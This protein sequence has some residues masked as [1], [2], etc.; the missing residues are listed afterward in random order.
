MSVFPHLHV[1]SAHSN[2][3]G[4]A[5][6]EELV[7]RVAEWGATEAAITDRDGLY[8]A[9][10]HIR[11]CISAGIAPV[12]GVDLAL[13]SAEGITTDARVTVL[14]HGSDALGSNAGLGW[15]ALCRL[16][17]AAHV[18]PRKASAT[19]KREH[20]AS[21]EPR[22]FAPFLL[23]ETEQQGAGR[24]GSEQLGTVLLGPHSDV[25]RALAAGHK[26]RARERLGQ[27]QRRLRG[28][29]A[30]EIVCHLTEPGTSASLSHAA[31]MLELAH[32]VRV[33][34]VLTNQARYLEPDDAVTGDVLDAAEALKPLGEFQPQPN[35]QAWLKPPERMRALA[36]LIV[37]RTSLGSA[38]RERLLGQTA[39]LAARCRLDPELDVRWR[40]PKVPEQ[41][42]LGITGD[43]D[44]VLRNRCLAALNERF[45]SPVGAQRETLERRLY[46]ELDTI[47]GFGFATYFLAVANVSELIRDMGIRNQARGSGAS[48][49]VNYL[50]RV[51]NVNPIEHDLVFERFL[52]NKRSTLPDID[53]DV[54]SDRRHEIYRAIF[55]RYGSER[56]TLLSM[57][58]TYRARGAARDAGLALGLE[59]HR[60]DEIA[61]SLWR[62]NAGQFREVLAEKPELAELA[63][64]AQ[65]DRDLN[66][67]IDLAERLD[68]LPRHLS[69]HP[70]GVLL[71]DATMLSTT[72]V[73]PSGIGLP[74][75]QYDKDDIDDMGL[76]KLDV[77]G[78]RMQSSLAYAVKEVE[79]VHGAQAAVRGGLSPD[80][81]YVSPTGHI[82]LDEIPKD[83]ERTFEAIRST[84]TLGMFQ[85]ESPGQR[86]L[87]GKMQPDV[88]EDLIADISLFRP[89]PMKGNMVGPFLDV[90]HGFASPKWLHPD[91]R[92]FLHET[93]GVVVYHEQVLRIFHA[94]MGISLAEADEL[95]RR[96]ERSAEGIE[97]Q[98][99]AKTSRNLDASGKRKFTDRQI[100]EIWDVLKGFGS[101]GFCK[102]HAAAFALPT[103]Q[104]AWLKTHYPAEFF[105]GLLTHD[106]G[107]YPKRLLLGD[108]R[109][110]GVPILPVDVQVS[111]EH[112]V[113]ERVRNTPPGWATRTGD[114]GIRLALAEIRGMNEAERK[115]IIAE[116]PYESL[117]DFLTRAR[118]SRPLAERLALI[119]ALDTLEPGH[120]TRGELLAAIR[121][122]PRIRPKPAAPDALEL[123]LTLG[124]H[125]HAPVEH[126]GEPE[127]TSR[128]R[129]Q[130]ELDVLA[131]DLSE[132]VIDSYRP[133][134]DELGVTPAGE[135]LGM[136]GGTEV[137]VAGVRVATQTPPMR[138]GKRVVFISVDDGTGCAD[139][140]FFEDAQ[141]RSGS[142]LFGTPLLLIQ[143]KVRRTGDRGV[144]VQADA[145]QDLKRVWEDWSSMRS[146]VLA[147]HPTGE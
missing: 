81:S 12:V 121:R 127:L 21:L 52:G 87:I 108:A 139:A 30:V 105:A 144:S 90:K 124:H 46:Q 141:E 67:L 10:R 99:R 65:T 82:V 98:F 47:S 122:R 14:A 132:H 51:S 60:V 104:S 28:A 84:H 44:R 116:A 16:I 64:K 119:G 143:G 26:E 53:I 76:L 23:A 48:S 111:T 25:G 135:L 38:A 128:E 59:D 24:D 112:F 136:R 93:Y 107:M 41:G 137:T 129:M 34:A 70:C 40:Q 2:H 3:Y 131:L 145:A 27:W 55:N 31:A 88:Y 118:P 6:P 83:D 142:V 92:P 78:V 29:I 138:S 74:M 80:V 109:R 69:M 120:P 18:P 117:G 39:E 36:D 1:A 85:I 13:R 94:C 106:P 126:T 63:E 66:L 49:L 146:S 72:P 101:F 140:T 35:G 134:L 103:W 133:L 102:A 115:R 50:L 61:K 5:R 73:Q 19:A 54:E 37:S 77:L 62:F 113:V 33:P 89:G 130:A 22:R 9:V 125:G 75:S 32:D 7:A 42:V 20:R 96:M 123:P 95:R 43:S 68:R 114:L 45:D 4:T 8:G 110:I 86:E 11:A 58:S 17:S 91:F 147:T 97:E 79:R 71:G 57:H 56:V 100:D 15:A